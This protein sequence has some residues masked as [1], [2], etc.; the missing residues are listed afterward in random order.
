MQRGTGHTPSLAVK[1]KKQEAQRQQPLCFFAARQR[2]GRA[3]GQDHFAAKRKKNDK[4][5]AFYV[6]EVI[7]NMEYTGQSLLI[8]TCHSYYRRQPACGQCPKPAASTATVGGQRAYLHARPPARKRCPPALP[9]RRC[10]V[11]QHSPV[12]CTVMAG[13]TLNH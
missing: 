10:A 1:Q 12:P 11:W 7:Y 6:Q 13:S 5:C 3:R 2:R 4:K 8:A 9:T